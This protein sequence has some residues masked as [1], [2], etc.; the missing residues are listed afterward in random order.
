MNK[1]R[2]SIRVRTE[3]TNELFKTELFDVT[4]SPAENADSLYHSSKLDILKR[5]PT[6]NYE[7]ATVSK[8]NDP[9]K[10]IHLSL[11]TKIIHLSLNENTFLEFADS[12]RTII[13]NVTFSEPI[14]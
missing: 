12:L 4:Q 8:T 13:L 14:F 3:H 10:I 7:S 5:F 2:K 6:C 11:F 9:A 1:I